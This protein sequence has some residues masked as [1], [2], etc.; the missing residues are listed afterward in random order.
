M[1]H[2]QLVWKIRPSYSYIY[3]Y[4]GKTSQFDTI[5]IYHFVLCKYN[6]RLFDNHMNVHLYSNVSYK[7]FFMLG[8]TIAIQ[9]L[10]EGHLIMF[11]VCI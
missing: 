9:L 4:N 10:K 2:I 11:T 8:H 1:N 6:N 5:S 3:Q 7:A